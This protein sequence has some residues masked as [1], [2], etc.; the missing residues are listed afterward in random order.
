LTKVDA[1]NFKH[2]LLNR[3]RLTMA[4]N[5]LNIKQFIDTV[6]GLCAEVSFQCCWKGG[7]SEINTL[8]ECH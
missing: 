4:V 3:L 8:S 6:K 5:V 1:G 2:E 7:L